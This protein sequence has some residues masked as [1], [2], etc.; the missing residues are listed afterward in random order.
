[1]VAVRGT[2]AFLIAI[3]VLLLASLTQAQG[4]PPAAPLTLIS[5]EGRRPV[6]TTVVSGQELIA[7]DDVASLFQVAVGEDSLAGGVTVTY[8]GR[9]IVASP[10]Q[11]M[12]SVN[13]RVVTLPSAIVR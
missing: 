1:M 3:L 13:G 11:P 2:A 6:P 12:A 5:R 8:R 4:T 9:T 7:L 10:D